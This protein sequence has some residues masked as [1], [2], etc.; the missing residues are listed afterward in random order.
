[1][2][3]GKLVVENDFDIAAAMFERFI[4]SGESVVLIADFEVCAVVVKE[5]FSLDDDGFLFINGINLAE[6]EWDGYCGPFM[7]SISDDGGVWCEKAYWKDREEI[8]RFEEDI[9]IAD[10]KYYGKVIKAC[11]NDDAEI[12]ELLYSDD[13]STEYDDDSDNGNGNGFNIIRTE[14]GKPRGI[15]CSGSGDGYCY[16]MKIC[17]CEPVDLEEITDMYNSFMDYLSFWV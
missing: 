15:E 14:E 5:L 11:L 16:E 6:P 2:K 7:L 3:K 9:V 8:L 17:S 10:P 1:M 4:D 13:L 12:S